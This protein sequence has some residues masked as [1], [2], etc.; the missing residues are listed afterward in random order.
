MRKLL[1]ILC[2]T[3][4]LICLMLLVSCSDNSQ[5]VTEPE[6]EQPKAEQTDETDEQSE[7]IEP[8]Q[9]IETEESAAENKQTDGA[10]TE[11]TETEPEEEP[12]SEES[13]ASGETELKV[14]PISIPDEE[15]NWN[16]DYNKPKVEFDEIQPG[17]KAQNTYVGYDGWIF[18]GDTIPDYNGKRTFSNTRLKKIAEKMRDRL[19]WCEKNGIKMYFVIVPNKNTVYPEYMPTE[20]YTLDDPDTKEPISMGEERAIDIVINYLRENT[21][22]TVI[23]CREGLMAA[24]EQYPDEELFYK[25]DT[26]WNNHGGFA[27]YSQIMD[28]ICADF[29]NAVK[30]T[31]DEYQIDYFDAYFKDEAYYLGWYDTLKNDGPVYTLK[32]GLTATMTYRQDSGPYG[33]F[34]HQ[35]VQDDGYADKTD[36]CIF[37][38][39]NIADAP[40]MYMVRDSFA[41]ALIPF[42]KDSFSESIYSWT[43]SVKRNEIEEKHPDILILEVVERSLT[44]FFNQSVFVYN[45]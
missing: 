9:Q 19:E 4:S 27:A 3:V 29:P 8:V 7:Q 36:Y 2:F 12:V 14:Y 23:D 40:T 18:Y 45:K 25:L 41:I 5:S 21:S 24:K 44:D 39:E 1:I 33:E 34:I 13:E 10:E 15:P 17:L 28:V 11:K 42:L 30:H 35:Y 31:K 26:H 22:V 20:T 37:K 16:A 6:V 43:L 38:N 32:S